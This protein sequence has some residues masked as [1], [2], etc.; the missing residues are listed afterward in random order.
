MPGFANG[1]ACDDTLRPTEADLV[2]IQI[3]M[4]RADVVKDAGNRSATSIEVVGEPG[5]CCIAFPDH[6]VPP[7]GRDSSLQTGISPECAREC[8]AFGQSDQVSSPPERPEPRSQPVKARLAYCRV[9]TQEPVEGLQR[10]RIEVRD[11]CSFGIGVRPGCE[12]PDR[13]VRYSLIRNPLVFRDPQHSA[14]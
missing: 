6:L 13:R 10:F 1:T 3:R 11:R 2:E 9:D 4:L 7:P 12:R 14:E 5:W 8:D